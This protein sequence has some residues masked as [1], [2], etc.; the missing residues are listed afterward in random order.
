MAL[1]RRFDPF[2][3]FCRVQKAQHTANIILCRVPRSSTRQTLTFAVCLTPAHGKG[4]NV[5]RPLRSVNGAMTSPCAAP[6]HTAK[7]KVAVCWAVGT[8]RMLTALSCSE[9]P[10]MWSPFRRG[11]SGGYTAKSWSPCVGPGAHGE[12]SSRRVLSVRRVFCSRRTAKFLF[13]VCPRKSTR[14]TWRLTANSR[15]PVL[16]VI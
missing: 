8:R 5:H 15:F 4:D 1:F 2:L 11:L 6:G 3:L 13:T 12:V 9:R 16:S 7:K 14:Q 10:L